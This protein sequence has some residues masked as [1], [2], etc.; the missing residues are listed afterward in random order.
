[1]ARKTAQ[2]KKT[3]SNNVR[4]CKDCGRLFELSSANFGR[5]TYLNVKGKRLY[6][7]RYDCHSCRTHRRLTS[8]S[9]V[10]KGYQTKWRKQRVIKERFGMTSQK[11]FSERFPR[12]C[13]ICGEKR[14]G[15]LTPI[16][17]EGELMGIICKRCRKYADEVDFNPD[18]IER[19][20]NLYTYMKVSNEENI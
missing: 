3:V 5:A 13:E 2:A 16:K 17:V 12:G 20:I 11:A 6:Y 18:T 15:F 14:L 7:Y 8:P 10:G 4:Q 1:M 9:R 19:A